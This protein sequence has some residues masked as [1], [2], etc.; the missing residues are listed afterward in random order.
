MQVG[1][2]KSPGDSPSGKLRIATPPNRIISSRCILFNE[3]RFPFPIAAK[4]L[5]S[6]FLLLERVNFIFPWS[7]DTSIDD[8]VRLS[9]LFHNLFPLIVGGVDPPEPIFGDALDTDTDVGL[10]SKSLGNG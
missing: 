6:L 5:T 8:D 10:A 4:S 3:S 7:F 9:N 1:M 2:S